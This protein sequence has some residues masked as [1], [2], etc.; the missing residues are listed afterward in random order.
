MQFDWSEGGSYFVN[1]NPGKCKVFV[2]YKINDNDR[3]FSCN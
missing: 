2:M 3:R 1:L